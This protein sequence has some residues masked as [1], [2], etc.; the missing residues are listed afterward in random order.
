MQ[1]IPCR[2]DDKHCHPLQKSGRR[3][4]S[5]AWLCNE[6]NPTQLSTLKLFSYWFR[7]K[8]FGCNVTHIQILLLL[9]MWRLEIKKKGLDFL[10][11]LCFLWVWEFLPWASTD[12]R[13]TSECN[14]AAERKGAFLQFWGNVLIWKEISS[15]TFYALTNYI[16]NLE[17]FLKMHI[18]VFFVED[19]VTILFEGSW[20][21]V[22]HNFRL[23]HS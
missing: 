23:F 14:T 7:L 21:K 18:V 17:L 8:C 19:T 5:A 9:L 16:N 1:F 11:L 13:I 10:L 22:Q 2:A 6:T 20:C 12:S 15:S 4:S 3:E